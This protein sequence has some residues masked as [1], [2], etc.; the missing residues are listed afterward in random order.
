MEGDRWKRDKTACTH[1]SVETSI[2]E[3]PGLGLGYALALGL[4]SELRYASELRHA[5]EL[6]HASELV[7]ALE[8]KINSILD[9]PLISDMS[10][11]S[12]FHLPRNRIS[13][14]N[15]RRK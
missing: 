8:L 1:G 12:H 4:A 14:A 13:D 15:G 10:Q 3:R 6:G 9:R 11:N 5:S 7:H 2:G